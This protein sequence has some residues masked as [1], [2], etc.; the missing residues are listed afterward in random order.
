MSIDVEYAIKKDVRN[1]PIVRE[2]DRQQRTDFYRTAGLAGLIVLMLLFATW[3]HLR[4]VKSGYQVAE[5]KAQR[6]A[7]AAANRLLRLDV[8][9]LSA[10]RVIEE[11]AIRELHMIVPASSDLVFIDRVKT[12]KPSKSVVAEVH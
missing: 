12:G 7:A 6:E 1:N 8:E 9:R 3:Q 2:V 11:R 10:P 5:L 4:V